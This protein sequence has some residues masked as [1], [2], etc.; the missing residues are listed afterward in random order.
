[1][2]LNKLNSVFSLG[3]ALCLIQSVSAQ[4]SHWNGTTNNTLWNVA[5]NWSPAGIPT[6]GDPTVTYTG[7]VWLDPS[8]V[9]GDTVITIPQGFLA[10]PGV[11][12][13][14][15][16]YNTIFGPEF[17]CT[18][19]VY[20]TLTFDWTIAP[21]QPDPTPGARSHIN[22][23]GNSYMYTT[24]ASL[25]LGS[26][27][28]PVCE[29]AYVTMN[30]YSNANY[31]SLG[32]AGGWIGG[33]IN[34][35]DESSVL[36]NGYVNIDNGQANNDGTTVF[37]VDGGTLA[38]PEGFIT[39]TVTNWIE[40][41]MIRVY[42][43]GYDTNDVTISDN[44]TN[45]IITPA[46]LG[47]ALQLV[48]FQ[49]LVVSSL[50]AGDFEQTTLVGDYPSVR[51]VL[52]GSSEPGLS[53]GSFTHPTYTSSNPKV[54]TVDTNGLITAVGTGSSTLTA[55]VGGFATTNSV[56]I[57]VSSPGGTLIHRYSFTG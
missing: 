8:P 43:K 1:M 44:G 55:T 50:T 40:R 19:N 30:L 3:M 42:G 25:N 38:L 36:L 20:G 47:G 57:S 10:D 27:W 18:F 15:E 51:G 41:G 33:H 37:A 6:N 49:P 46:P 28:W 12:N 31:S 39:T 4:D 24:G 35:Y 45:T 5:T 11:G 14:A 22:M 21:Y 53:P 56:V 29:G 7:N 54:A 48:Y 13:S 2:K 23:Y 9:D 32:G 34:M 52:L 16:V 17:G 26:G